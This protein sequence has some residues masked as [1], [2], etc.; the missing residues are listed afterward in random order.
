MTRPG[1]EAGDGH[2]TAVFSAPFLGGS[3]LFN[4]EYLR[5]VREQGIEIDAVI[6]EHGTLEV[7]LAP[8]VRSLQIVR[9]PRALQRISR[10]DARLRAPHL[11]AAAAAVAAY[12]LRLRLALRRTQGPVVCFGLRAQLAVGILQRTLGRRVCWVVHEVVPP[13]AFAG[14]WG[15]AA[16]RADEIYAYSTTAATQRNLRGAA[17]RTMAVRLQLGRFAQLAPPGAPPQVLGLIGDLFPLKNHLAL[18][19]V[20]RELRDR[21]FPVQGVLVGRDQIGEKNSIDDYARAVHAA[22]DDP[23]SLVRLISATPERMPEVM[24]DIDVLLHLSAIPETFGRVCA[25][26]MAAARPVIAYDHG[27]V[28]E[29]VIDGATGALCA[30]GDVAAVES[31]FARMYEDPELFR[32]L[33]DGARRHAVSQYGEQQRSAT[34][35]EGLAEFAVGGASR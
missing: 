19:Q 33:S 14:A 3:E 15:R 2:L 4:L 20:V 25:E 29:I 28:A 35:A 32:R 18:V 34:I 27:A 6:P 7:A 5:S 9:V 12:A 31:A 11:V 10:F 17:V 30:P 24:S 16:H 21:G 22:A 13:G 26:A 8:L 1:R 23:E